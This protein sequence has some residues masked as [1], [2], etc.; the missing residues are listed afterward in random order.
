MGS[1]CSIPDEELDDLLTTTNFN[2]ED[3]NNHYKKF[4][5]I[6]PQGETCGLK[7]YFIRCIY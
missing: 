1:R 2:R 7:L 6:S 4:I 5:E 3:L